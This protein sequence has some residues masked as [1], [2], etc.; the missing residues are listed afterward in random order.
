MTQHVTV[1]IPATTANL[2]PGFDCLG[3]ALSLYNSISVTE[4]PEEKLIIEATGIDAH[5]IP[6]NASNLVVKSAKIIFDHLGK[7]PPGMHIQQHNNI[8]VGSGLGSS[9]TAVLGG[10]L[11]ANALVNGG[12]SRAEILQFA[13]DLEGHPDNVAPAIYG[14]LVL[15]IQGSHGLHVEQIAIPSLRVAVV[16]P[17]FE[18]LTQ[19]ARAAL[20]KQVS[21]QD[22]IFNSSRLGLLIRA[23]Q[24]AD[25]QKMCLAMQDRLHQPYRIPIIPGMAAAFNAAFNAGAASVA[26]SGA[27]PS[28]IAFGPSKHQA[29]G[30]A[31]QDAFAHAGLDSRLW[32]LNLDISGSSVAVE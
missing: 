3:M 23:L 8:P 28:L 4:L 30:E 11:A 16:L 15:G 21:M 31:A 13:T 9:S 14:G 7:R 24:T 20:P 5:K 32:V 26:L 18:L 6:T 27:G 22:A 2:G 10:M 1:S 29:I 12:L 19:D 25:Y 17:D